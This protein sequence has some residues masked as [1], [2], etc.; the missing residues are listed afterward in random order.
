MGTGSRLA[1]FDVLNAAF[2][3]RCGIWDSHWQWKKKT[4]EV[5]GSEQS[6]TAFNPS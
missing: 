4:E 2:I 3:G 1:S 6:N 5:F